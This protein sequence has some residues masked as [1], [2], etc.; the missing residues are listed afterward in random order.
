MKTLTDRQ[1]ELLTF[2]E[3]HV[4]VHGFPPSIREMADH[5]GI[6]ST[7]GVNDHLKAL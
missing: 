1:Q 6:R 2:I 3:E 5:M 7:N 4:R